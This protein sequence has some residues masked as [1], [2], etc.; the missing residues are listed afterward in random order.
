MQRWLDAA[1]TG[2]R[3]YALIGVSSNVPWG[4]ASSDLVQAVF[5]KNV[6]A[7]VSL[8]RPSSHLGEQIALKAF[9]PVLAISSDRALT[10]ANIPWIF[11]LPDGTSLASA[12]DTLAGAVREAGPDRSKLRQVL[13]SGAKLGQVQFQTTGEPK[14]N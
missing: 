2:N 14:G 12:L 9:L 6:V 10:S 5:D 3:H 11:R 4:K 7:I 13:A 1:N 8:D